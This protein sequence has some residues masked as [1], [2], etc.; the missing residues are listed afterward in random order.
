MKLIQMYK[1]IYQFGLII[2][3]I[4]A[5]NPLIAFGIKYGNEFLRF[6]T[7]VR[8]SS[9][10]GAVVSNSDPVV[11]AYWNPAILS[12]EM[13]SEIQIM[14]TEEFAGVVNN[15][16]LFATLPHMKGLN[17][18]AGFF[19]TGVDHIPATENALIE[20]GTENGQLDAGDRIDHSKISYFNASESAFFLAGS[21]L[22]NRNLS[23]G[24]TFKTIYKNLYKN[25]ALGFGLDIGGFYEPIK[26][27]K[28]GA[29]ARNLTTTFLFWED[30]EKE[31][32]KPSFALGG[33]YSILLKPINLEILPL[34]GLN[35]NFEGEQNNTDL[36][37]KNLNFRLR[38]GIE[39][40][41][42][43]L[44]ALRAGRDDLGG[45]HIGCG[46]NTQYGRL[47]YGFAM[48]EGYSEL[49]NS[50]R[51]ALTFKINSLKGLIKKR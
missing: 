37:I 15:D 29:V 28:M 24:A 16:H 50:H 47:D 44:F 2:F 14:H 32:I 20:Y 39:I 9:L 8:E 4:L 31:I 10:G 6:G 40:L 38:A 45:I 26:G 21:K 25:Y 23:L 30:G 3:F 34:T 36:N 5:T 41:Y 1:K 18:S 12:E 27:L 43:K 51:I 13:N 46:I 17:F 35:V 42:R 7:G 33:S 48:G 22:I 19:R 11:A 49:G